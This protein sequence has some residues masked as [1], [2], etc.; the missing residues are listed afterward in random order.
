VDRSINARI[1]NA[2]LPRRKTLEEFDF[3]FQPSVS[4]VIQ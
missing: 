2:R 3:A 4:A 1:A